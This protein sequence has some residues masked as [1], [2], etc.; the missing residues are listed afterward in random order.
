MPY[1]NV[2]LLRK[3]LF[4]VPGLWV[5]SPNK[6]SSAT[7]PPPT[8][9]EDVA[10]IIQANCVE[11]HRKGAPAPFPLDTLETVS[12]RKRIITEVVE[13]KLMPPWFAASD[14]GHWSN[15]RSLTAGERRTVLDWLRAGM[16]AGDPA[17]APEPRK[18]PEEW[19]IGEGT[20][21]EILSFEKPVTIP[22]DGDIPY[23]YV[24]IKTKFPEDRWV[25]AVEI[26]PGEKAVVH[27]VS[28]MID[29][30]M[31]P[32]GAG[33]FAVYVPGSSYNSYPEGMAKKL[34]AGATL[35]F[36]MHYTPIGKEVQDST[37]L[38]LV[39]VVVVLRFQQ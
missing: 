17:K 38:G 29:G 4:I 20:P 28:V 12:K 35:T 15:D 13:N 32:G 36:E 31:G 3:L 11:C 18:F 19:H 30:A 5:F 25:R 9:Y 33:I 37:R 10:E 22:A 21:D 39:V 1:L 34:P 24:K 23:E 14:V 2:I 8:Y 27:H 7:P 26:I 16:P 6:T